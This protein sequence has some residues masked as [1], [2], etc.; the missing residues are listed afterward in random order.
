MR[1]ALPFLFA[2]LAIALSRPHAALIPPRATRVL[3]WTIVILWLYQGL[4]IMQL[5]FG[6]SPTGVRW[7]RLADGIHITGGM[8][9]FHLSLRNG[10]VQEL[11]RIVAFALFCVGIGAVMTLAGVQDVEGGARRITSYVGGTTGGSA[12][13]A[14]AA[15]EA[16][17]GAYGHVYSF[18]LL[19]FPM[20][21]FLR[22]VNWT[23]R[24]CM[25]TLAAVLVVTVYEAEFTICMVGMAI[26]GVLFTLALLG[27]GRHLQRMVGLAAI[28]LTVLAASSPTSLRF[29]ADPLLTWS[30]ATTSSEY[31]TRI[32]SVVDTMDGADRSYFA[33]RSGL[34]WTSWRTFLKHPLFGMGPMRDLPG[35]R[36]FDEVKGGHSQFFDLMAEA[37]IFGLAIYVWFFAMHYRYLRVMS[38]A[39]LGSDWWPAYRIFLASACA[40]AFVNP[41]AGYTIYFNVLLYLPTLALFRQWTPAPR[42]FAPAAP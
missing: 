5:L 23:A 27:T 24:L 9:L 18:G 29:L 10:R 6:L 42:L 36:S 2:W 8:L 30:D 12:G 28:V 16:G 7:E 31:K 13:E 22:N 25:G 26:G 3:G 40:V 38:A 41:L 39:V 35:G 11:C 19:V 37:G 20:C 15:I 1:F 34:Y 32:N 14:V 33:Y 4:D 21:W 17:I